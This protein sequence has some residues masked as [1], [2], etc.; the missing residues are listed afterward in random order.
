MCYPYTV[1]VRSRAVSKA[2]PCGGDCDM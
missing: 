1:Q 2:K